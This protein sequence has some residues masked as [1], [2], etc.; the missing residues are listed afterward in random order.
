[1]RFLGDRD[2]RAEPSGAVTTAALLAGRIPVSGPTVLVV[3]G[4]N[5]DP[6]RYDNLVRA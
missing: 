6:E 3:T 5:V 1:M 4:G 2:I